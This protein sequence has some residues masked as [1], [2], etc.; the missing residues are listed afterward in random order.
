MLAD[1][2]S[3]HRKY[4]TVK[5][6]FGGGVGVMMESRQHHTRARL[7]QSI[8]NPKQTHTGT[9]VSFPSMG[10]QLDSPRNLS[11]EAIEQ[12]RVNSTPA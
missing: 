12:P 5:Q 4:L 9:D 7:T 1:L 6:G 10:T 11:A 2:G 3:R 8:K